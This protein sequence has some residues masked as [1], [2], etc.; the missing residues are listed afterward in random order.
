[1]ECSH[2]H[3]LPIRLAVEAR[4][5]APDGPLD[6][7]VRCHLSAHGGDEHHGLLAELD[8]YGTALWLRWHGSDVDLAVL[9]DCPVIGTGSG[10]GGDACCLF[11]GHVERHSWE[12]TPPQ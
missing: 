3:H 4:R 5:I 8:R 1:M 10:S 2:W 6:R 11:A 7:A 12:N 9:P